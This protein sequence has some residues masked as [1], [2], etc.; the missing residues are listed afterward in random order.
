MCLR[1]CCR[2]EPAR[3]KS[4]GGACLEARRCGDEGE[5]GLGPGRWA[6]SG[7]ALPFG[8][9]SEAGI[10]AGSV[11]YSRALVGEGGSHS[12]GSFRVGVWR[13]VRGD[14]STRQD[15]AA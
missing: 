14:A 12:R 2:A 13:V 5:E 7:L 11:L 4:C 10:G 3:V 9:V 8:A 15:A 6:G 1:W